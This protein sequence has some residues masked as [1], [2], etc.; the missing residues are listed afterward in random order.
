MTIHTTSHTVKFYNYPHPFELENGHALPDLRI[1]YT[2]MGRLNAARDNVIWICHA[3]TANAD[4]A[5]WWPGL[6]GKGKVLDPNRYFIVCANMLGSCYGTTGPNTV[7]SRTGAPYRQRFPQVTVRDMVRAHGLL[8]R[9]LGID[10]IRLAIGGSMG[11]QQVLEWAVQE[12]ERFDR[13]VLLATNARHSPWGIAFNEAQRMAIEADPSLYSEQPDS[14]A[15][16]LEAA[17]AMAMLSYR[18]YLT[19]QASQEDGDVNK[20]ENFRASSYQRHQ[21]AKLRKRFD[22][23]AYLALSRAMD[24]HHLGRGRDSVEQA[25]S[26]IQSPALVIGIRSDLL[27]P[28]EEQALIAQHI[29]RARLEVIDSIYGHDG[30]LLEGEAIEQYLR[31][32]LQGENKRRGYRASSKD[33]FGFK[34]NVPRALPGTESF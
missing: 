2:T 6:V 15:R 26:R 5:E 25:L 32:F 30:F 13:I 19:Y 34:Q 23:F 1:A 22:V 3:L 8:R 24:S 33:E 12:P 29:P 7:D 10:R 28:V 9:R 27:F 20:L 14:G 18:H 31:P 11:G 17:R 16:G 21:G 4:P